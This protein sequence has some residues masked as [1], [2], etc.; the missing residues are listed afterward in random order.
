MKLSTVAALAVALALAGCGAGEAARLRDDPVATVP[1]IVPSMRTVP[2]DGK[3]WVK[4]IL[5]N[6]L[7]DL[8]SAPYIS[9]LKHIIAYEPMAAH[10][11]DESAEVVG[12]DDSALLA[13][14]ENP[15]ALLPSDDAASCASKR[16][17]DPMYQRDP[18][19][20]GLRVLDI[21]PSYANSD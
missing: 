2:R 17:N 11:V 5:A 21:K 4:P 12:R 19:T 13:P 3:T 8:S 16:K 9:R 18:E 10:E 20:T 7:K 15:C 1:N 6:A 14:E